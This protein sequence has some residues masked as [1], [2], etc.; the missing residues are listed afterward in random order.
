MIVRH[1]CT[2][3]LAALRINNYAILILILDMNLQSWHRDDH[4]QTAL[5]ARYLIARGYEK[6]G[7]EIYDTVANHASETAN[8]V[9][10]VAKCIQK[11]EYSTL[12]HWLTG[13]ETQEP[14]PLGHL[15]GSDALVGR[16]LVHRAIFFE[17]ILHVKLLKQHENLLAMLNDVLIPLRHKLIQSSVFPTPPEDEQK[18]LLQ[19]VLST[20]DEVVHD[21]FQ[22]QKVPEPVSVAFANECFGKIRQALLKDFKLATQTSSSETSLT[23]TDTSNIASVPSDYL[24]RLLQHS[25]AHLELMHPFSLPP[26]LPNAGSRELELLLLPIAAPTSD[27]PRN[28]PAHLLHTLKHHQT[29]EVWIAKFSPLGRYLVL[30]LADGV[31]VIYDVHN[32]FE[33]IARLQSDPTKDLEAMVGFSDNANSKKAKSIMYCSWDPT[34][35]Y[36]VSSSVDTIIRV[37]WVGGLNRKHKTRSQDDFKLRCC[38]TIGLNI[39]AW[40]CE[41]LPVP[42]GEKPTFIVGSMD[43]KLKAYDIDGRELFD[44]FGDTEEATKPEKEDGP[45]NSFQRVTDL[46]ITPNGKILITTNNDKRVHFY[47]IPSL[48]DPLAVT[49]CLASISL[50]GR[51]TSCSISSSGDYLLFNICPDELQVWCIAPLA[52]GEPPYLVRKLCGFLQDSF[53]VR[54]CFGYTVKNSAGIEDEQLALT[55]S[56]DGYVYIWKLSSGGLVTRIRAHEGLVSSVEWNRFH[57]AVPLDPRDYGSLWC[58][59]SDDHT[60]KIWGPQDF[61]ST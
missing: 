6:Q 16:Y 34:E 54:S 5:L 1:P 29:N 14:N 32:K 24:F 8:G 10:P 42:H 60:V 9:S 3:F 40:T 53:T 52:K 56:K 18:Q 49:K 2:R 61:Y 55:G 36:L 48:V 13:A 45:I 51:L 30:G 58:S 17:A 33:V 59:V 44:F 27:P 47:S 28:F 22:L 15:V 46:A 37:W 4:V 43:K 31:L 23:K 20:A 57:Q 35:Q 21:M 12:L 39:K 11:G 38:F 41:F 19:L 25:Y 7:R 50:G 26:R